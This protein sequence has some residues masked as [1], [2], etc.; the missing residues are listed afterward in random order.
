MIKA[1]L[2]ENGPIISRSRPIFRPGRNTLPDHCLSHGLQE[3]IP[4]GIG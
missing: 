1:I 3:S 2:P 4:S